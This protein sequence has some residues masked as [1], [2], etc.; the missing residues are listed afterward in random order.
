MLARGDR[1]AGTMLVVLT[2]RGSPST[3]YE[4]MPQ[5]DGTRRWSVSRRQDTDEPFA[6]GEYLERRQAQDQ[7]LWIVELDVRNGERFIE[8]LADS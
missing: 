2:D 8:E 4:R 1:D 5:G 6:F 7:D 3:A